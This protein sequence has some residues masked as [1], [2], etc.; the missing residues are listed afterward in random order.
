MTFIST[1][2]YQYRTLINKPQTVQYWQ[3]FTAYHDSTHIVT[4]GL[5]SKH[6]PVLFSTVESENKQ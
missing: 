4:T 2:P 5:I 3:G 6:V 1:V